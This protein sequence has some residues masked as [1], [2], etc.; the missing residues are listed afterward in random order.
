[1]EAGV[2]EYDYYSEDSHHTY[3]PPI[4]ALFRAVFSED[5]QRVPER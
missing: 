2:P 1:M 4:D 5:S 3:P